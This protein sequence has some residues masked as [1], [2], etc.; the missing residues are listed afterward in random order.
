[1]N[2]D[3]SPVPECD[4]YRKKCDRFLFISINNP[5]DPFEDYDPAAFLRLIG[6]GIRTT[7]NDAFCAEKDQELIMFSG[8]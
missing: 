7:N 5:H 8:S 3:I 1:M 6:W 4:C 2:P